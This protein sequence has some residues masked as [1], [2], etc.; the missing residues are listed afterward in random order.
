VQ[1]RLS[2][3]LARRL[4]KG[5]RFHHPAKRCAARIQVVEYDNGLTAINGASGIQ[6]VW[7]PNIHPWRQLTVETRLQQVYV[8]HHLAMR[9]EAALHDEAA[10]QSSSHSGCVIFSPNTNFRCGTIENIDAGSAGD[11]D[12]RKVHGQRFRQPL[13][14]DFVHR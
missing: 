4:L 9:R 12:P 5:E 14:G 6:T 13:T 7:Q 11:F 8:G 1:L 2:F 3:E 10:R